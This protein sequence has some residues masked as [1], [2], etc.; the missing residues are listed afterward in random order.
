MNT[1][2][3]RVLDAEDKAKALLNAVHA[4]VS[5]RGRQRFD[6]DPASFASVPRSPFAY[7]VSDRF[8]RLFTQ[9]PSFEAEGRTAKVGLQSSDDF[10]FLKLWWEV[11][12]VLAYSGNPKGGYFSRYYA[13]VF[14]VVRWTDDGREIK[15]FAELT[16]GSNHWSRNIRSAAQYFRAGLTW[17]HRT[18]SELSLRAMPAG[19][20]FGSKGP[21]V[22][23]ENDDSEE[24]LVLLAVT[25]STTFA[26]CVAL[27]LA[28]ADA[29]ARSYDVGIIQRTPVPVLAEID[30]Q[31][32][33]DLARRAWSLSR[34]L[35]T[36]TETS[37]ALN[38]PALLQVDGTDLTSRVA[39]W[40]ERVRSVE[41]ELLAVQ[42]QINECCFVLYGLDED[43][44]RAVTEGFCTATPGEGSVDASK[45]SDADVAESGEEDES[46]ADATGL[47]AELLS[48]AVGVAFGRFDVR[49]GT[50]EREAPPE[51]EPFDPL[52]ACS[53]GMLTGEE[54]LPLNAPPAGY[55]I[56]FPGD[57]I[58]VDDAGAPRD[59]V[60]SA[61]QVFEHVFDDPAA[62]WE[63]A[64]EILGER[65]RTLR[66]W[67]GRDFFE[68]H[69]K[70]YSKSRRKAPIYWPLSTASGS[71]TVWLYYHRITADSLFQV[72]VEYLDPK[73]RKVQEERLQVESRLGRAE[74]REAAK[75]AKLAGELAELEQELEEMKAELL[76]VAELPYKP[77][78][79][80]G[81]QITAAPLWKL[82]RLQAW[83]KILEA[84]WKKLAKG[85]YDWAH[86]S[87]AIWPERVR[88]KC[89]TDR[90]LAIAHELED[91]C[92][93]ELAPEKKQRRKHDV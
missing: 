51:P 66:Q 65:D 9:I 5:T 31:L 20:I 1:I 92:E 80:D 6:V 59:L 13:D 25:N 4:P 35:D 2:F 28:A 88:E 32:L 8:R 67:F 49:P 11:G 33:A 15:A 44:R 29:A 24:L 40:S 21:A 54:G 62:R 34:S 68:F 26:A 7:W 45:A 75:L 69:L 55:P 23:V 22:L 61:R 48:W 89:K 10:R 85:D 90:S 79:N 18:T 3:V 72:V 58:L 86:L 91:L 77:D 38:L 43:D 93:V 39:S 74:G 42:A 63:E 27:Q 41:E 60:A 70:Q 73:I 57:G 81:V 64:A 46:N 17:S 78:L 83:R 37:H 84:T 71:H 12:N 53:P 76:R 52:P 82:F 36:R 16:P 50:A 30:R 19:C 87:H 14:L 56:D 47:A